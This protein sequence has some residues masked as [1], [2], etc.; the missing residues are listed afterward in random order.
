MLQSRAVPSLHCCRWTYRAALVP[1][2]LQPH[3]PP[4]HGERST[5][6]SEHIPAGAGAAS[7]VRAKSQSSAAELQPVCHCKRV[8]TTGPRHG[9][10]DPEARCNAVG[11]WREDIYQT[12]EKRILGSH[13][14]HEF[15]P[16]SS[17]HWILYTK[18]LQMALPGSEVGFRTHVGSVLH[19]NSGDARA[20]LPWNRALSCR[21]QTLLNDSLGEARPQHGKEGEF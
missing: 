6:C 20:A 18:E 11:W 19:G 17:Q 9:V 7:C 14:N 2:S 16:C 15:L 13:N 8:D 1:G 3:S 12:G 5:R 4:S 21:F 10:L